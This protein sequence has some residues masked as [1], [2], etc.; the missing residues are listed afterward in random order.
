MPDASLRYM[1]TAVYLD[2]PANRKIDVGLW[3]S[4]FLGSNI[5]D[6]RLIEELYFGL[7]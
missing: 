6:E 4:S 1:S 5:T 7:Y 3:N 2:L